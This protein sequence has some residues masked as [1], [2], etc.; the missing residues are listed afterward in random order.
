MK[1]LMAV[2][3]VLALVYV[4]AARRIAGRP[5]AAVAR[6][7]MGS[8]AAEQGN[9]AKPVRRQAVRPRQQRRPVVERTVARSAR[10]EMKHDR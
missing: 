5:L 9:Q 6:L 2:T 10:R 7:V 1:R 8:P 3:V 4:P